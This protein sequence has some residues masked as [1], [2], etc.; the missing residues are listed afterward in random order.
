MV[1]FSLKFRNVESSLCRMQRFWVS[2]EEGPK[3]KGA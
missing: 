3:G 1:F 2:F